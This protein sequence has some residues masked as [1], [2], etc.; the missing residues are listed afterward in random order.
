[1]QCVKASFLSMTN[2]CWREGA[3]DIKTKQH[4]YT[5]R[6][7]DDQLPIGVEI[8]VM[9]SGT[10]LMLFIQ[11]PWNPFDSWLRDNR[12]D[13]NAEV[14]MACLAWC[15]EWAAPFSLVQG[16]W[17]VAHLGLKLTHISKPISTTAHDTVHNGLFW[18]LRS[19]F[20]FI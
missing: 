17:L 1:M 15:N 7:V 20:W 12:W 8:F 4:D 3:W 2:M 13:L 16:P 5:L 9:N 6:H 14:D 18:P 10:K 19:F 11:T